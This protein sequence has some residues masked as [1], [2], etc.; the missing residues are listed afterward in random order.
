[1]DHAHR[2]DHYSA[3]K[4]IPPNQNFTRPNRLSLL[5]FQQRSMNVTRPVYFADMQSF[6]SLNQ[7]YPFIC[8]F[9]LAGFI[10]TTVL[11]YKIAINPFLAQVKRCSW[12]DIQ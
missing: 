10:G 11:D 4:E 7:L 1:M 8:E 5:L 2:Q 12:V 9:I 3:G 6:H